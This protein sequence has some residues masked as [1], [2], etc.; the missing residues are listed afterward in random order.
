MSPSSDDKWQSGAA[1][2]YYMGRW[3]A[4]L[5]RPFVEW[6]DVEPSS[7]WLDVGCGTGA[8][9][10][11]ICEHGAP[12]SVVGCDSAE[13]FVAHARKHVE[14]ARASFVVADAAALPERRGGFDAIVSGLVL[15][16]LP[17]PERALASM[18]ERLAEHGV[19]AAYVWDYA[20]GTEFLREFWAEAAS[21]PR[22]AALD[23]RTRFPLCEPGALERLFRATGFRDVS[24]T[25]L[26]IP[27]VFVDLEDFWQPFLG[28]TGPAPAY[29]AS[30]EPG[31]RLELRD[32]LARRLP[33]DPDGSIRLSARAWAARGAVA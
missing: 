26:E 30:L 3:S 25:A 9:T 32:R 6:L 28:G 17:Q 4:S 18:R 19:A 1:Y 27:T 29:V 24:A 2:E 31:Q 23:E 12:A 20:A 5:A 16:F 21:D 15:N 7:H 33:T 14:D 13:A 8:L 10:R 22:A 11:A